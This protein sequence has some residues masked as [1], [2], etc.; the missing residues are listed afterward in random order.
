MKQIPYHNNPGNACALACYTMI[1]QYLLPDADVTFEQ[2]GKIADWHPG[3]VVWEAPVFLWLMTQGVHITDHDVIDLN[4]WATEGVTGL[5]K[6]I[7]VGEFKWYQENTYDFDGL[8]N[9]V[10]AMA[11]HPN[12]TYIQHKPTWEDIVAD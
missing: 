10:K 11:P 5:Q 2:L 9:D 6:T 8:T 4:A 1:A 3:Y 12:F 7:P